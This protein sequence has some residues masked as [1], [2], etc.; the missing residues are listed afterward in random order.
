[1]PALKRTYHIAGSDA[2]AVAKRLRKVEA[3]ARSNKPEVKS[4]TY[5]ASGSLA[6]GAVINAVPSQIAE[7]TGGNERIGDAIHNV[8][9]EVRGVCDQLLDIHCL[10]A[11]SSTLPVMAIFTSG[12]GTF[13]LDSERDSRFR[14]ILHY[15]NRYASGSD[16]TLQFN[17]KLN[18]KT[19]YNGAA[20]TA[21]QR[22]QV[23]VSVVNRH[24]AALNYHFTV[25]LFYTDA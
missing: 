8:R 6:A 4:I 11:N 1:M 15:R 17:R 20:S 2:E 13:L 19:Y 14:E 16:K 5:V 10:V 18:F 23:V 22:G 3:I 12:V 25:R 7:G 9:I 24:T 21:G